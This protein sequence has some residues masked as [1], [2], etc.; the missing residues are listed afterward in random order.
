M[1]IYIH[2][3]GGYHTKLVFIGRLVVFVLPYFVSLLIMIV[4]HESERLRLREK[5]ES[6]EYNKIVQ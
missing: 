5:L 6:K 2:A 4:T 3:C 1:I